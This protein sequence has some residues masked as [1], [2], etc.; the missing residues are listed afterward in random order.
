MNVTCFCRCQLLI[1]VLFLKFG[2]AQPVFFSPASSVASLPTLFD[3]QQPQNEADFAR[4]AARMAP[5]SPEH[6]YPFMAMQRYPMPEQGFP[7]V[8]HS[9]AG[10]EPAHG[11]Q[12]RVVYQPMLVRVGPDGTPWPMQDD[13]PRPDIVRDYKE[14]EVFN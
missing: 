5:M 3:I 6:N 14:A 9:M 12:F 10:P 11:G 13:G 8:R 1:E 7:G 2:P 4:A